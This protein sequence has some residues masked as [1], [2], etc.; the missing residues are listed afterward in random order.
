MQIKV[1]PNRSSVPTEG[2]DIGYL[3]TD[4]WNDWFK[5][6]TLYVLTYFDPNGEKHKIGAVKIGEFNWGKVQ[7]DVC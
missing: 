7:P 3:W 4:N 1:I 6:H 2:R 5:Y